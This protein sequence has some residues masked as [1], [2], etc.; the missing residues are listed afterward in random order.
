[1]NTLN[2]QP[3]TLLLEMEVSVRRCIYPQAHSRKRALWR[4]SR[5]AHEARGRRPARKKL[6]FAEVVLVDRHDLNAMSNLHAN[7]MFVSC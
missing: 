5:Q 3:P 6:V 2:Q 1:M 7:A 4:R